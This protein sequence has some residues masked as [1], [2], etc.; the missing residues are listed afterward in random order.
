MQ[1]P[2]LLMSLNDW[3]Q[4]DEGNDLQS[5]ILRRLLALWEAR[6]EG[7]RLPPREAFPAEELM[8]LGGRVVLLEVEN[9]PFRLRFRL[10]GTHVTRIVDRDMTGHF[11]D[12]VY[13]PVYWGRLETH[14][15]RVIDERRALRMHGTMAHSR[16]PHVPAES[17]DMPL[18]GPDGAV[19]MIL[20]GFDFE[21]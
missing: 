16:K 15:R 8:Q 14:F 2:K 6:W 5:P 3:W 1:K 20:Q 4:V 19:A 7:D 10:L 9:D 17:I 13:E 11:L 18:A 21:I 12:E